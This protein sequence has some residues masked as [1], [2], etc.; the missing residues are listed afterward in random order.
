MVHDQEFVKRFLREAQLSASLSHPNI[1]TVYDV[2]SAG[3][4]HYMAMEY[5][6]GEDLHQM[7][8]KQGALPADKLVKWIIPI[9]EALD[10]IHKK[11]LLHRDVKSPNIFITKEGRPILMDFGIAHAADGT[12]LTQTGSV[13]GTPEYMS[14]EQANGLE[15]TA[16]SDLWSLGIVFYECL[17]GKVPFHGDNP[18]TTIHLVTQN[19]P[20]SITSQNSQ[21]PGWFESIVLKLLAKDPKERFANGTELSAA[22]RAEKEIYIG[23]RRQTTKQEKGIISPKNKPLRILPYII[24]AIALFIVVTGIEMV[25]DS[26]TKSSN[27]QIAKVETQAPSIRPSNKDNPATKTSTTINYTSSEAIKAARAAE[28]EKAG[29]YLMEQNNYTIAITKYDSALVFLPGNPLLSAKRQITQT[30]LK[31]QQITRADA[32]KVQAKVVTQG[33]EPKSQQVVE[34][35]ILRQQ[36]TEKSSTEHEQTVNIDEPVFIIV[37]EQATFQGGDVNTFRDWVMKS[38]KYPVAAAENGITGKV[39]VQYAVNSRGVVVDVKV[40]R[41]VDLSLDK[42]AIRVIM[43]SPKWN[44][45]KQNGEKVKQQFTIPISFILK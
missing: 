15:L 32:Q 5:L 28:F 38:I 1:V 33:K 39:Y 20:V 12:K 41:G 7:I 21:I 2:D 13:M 14:P 29:D 45:G 44:P 42:E 19:Q 4:V 10:Y 27:K 43:S 3:Q 17:I 11:G 18:L 16:Q 6:E 22:L 35:K 24:G 25:L 31:K 40:V 37:D 9:A 34:A 36:K 8:K 30:K 23:L 26:N